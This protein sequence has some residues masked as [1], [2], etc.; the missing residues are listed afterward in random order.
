M[1]LSSPHC[2]SITGPGTAGNLSLVVSI[3]IC[4]HEY[5]FLDDLPLLSTQGEIHSATVPLSWGLL[6]SGDI[7]KLH[8]IFP[9]SSDIKKKN[10]RER[11][12]KRKQKKKKSSPHTLLA[13]L[14]LWS[15]FTRRRTQQTNLLL[16]LQVPG[17]LIKNS[18][19]YPSLRRCLSS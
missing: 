12:R 18:G 2:T 14:W 5:T 8:C 6:I 1:S 4:T 16:W 10:Q 13:P 15:T 19:G 9:C 17:A 3:S 7:K 11:E